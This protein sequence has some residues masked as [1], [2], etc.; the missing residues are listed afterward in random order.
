MK[1]SDFSQMISGLEKVR[2]GNGRVLVVTHERPDGDA[3][4]SSTGM[5]LLLRENGFRADLLMPDEA[6]LTHI[7]GFSALKPVASLNAAE[8]NE[9]YFVR[10]NTDAST[11][12]TLGLGVWCSMR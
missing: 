4:G 10:L 9:K 2:S 11:V 1:A 7:S 3:I 6:G 12:K 8:V 5:T